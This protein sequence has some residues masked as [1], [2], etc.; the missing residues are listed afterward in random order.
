MKQRLTPNRLRILAACTLAMLLPLLA[1]AWYFRIWSWHDF[2][3][4]TAMRAEC[5]PVW[6]ELH[7]GRIHAGQNV[8]EIITTTNPIRIDRFGDFVEL[9]YHGGQPNTVSFT[10]VS[11]LAHH[12]RLASAQAH[13]CT[14]S[15]SFFDELTPTDRSNY[16][17]AYTTHIQTLAARLHPAPT[18]NT[19][20]P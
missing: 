17:A 16:R 2:K 13:S 1:C 18:T 6:R 7:F 3:V 5:H 4:Y 20:P 14:W 12:G 11:I 9:Y 10:Q 19:T 8:E 15:R